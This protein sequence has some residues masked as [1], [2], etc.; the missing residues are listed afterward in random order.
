M[1]EEIKIRKLVDSDCT[2]HFKFFKLINS[3]KWPVGFALFVVFLID[4]IVAFYG[5]GILI[6]VL[7]ELYGD[8]TNGTGNLLGALGLFWAIIVL[9]STF[10][11]VFF[12][13]LCSEKRETT[14]KRKREKYYRKLFDVEDEGSGIE[15]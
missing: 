5:K 1:D 9:L 6:K 15:K 13:Y 14:Y 12:Q 8:L 10:L 4:T 2:K 3:I 11:C 7:N